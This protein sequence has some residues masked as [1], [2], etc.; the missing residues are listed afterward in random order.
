MRV[1]MKLEKE[2]KGTYRYEEV[3]ETGQVKEHRECAIG[4]LY[5]KK[6]NFYNRAAPR[7]IRVEVTELSESN[8]Q[9]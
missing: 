2:T 1:Y 7:G 3:T 6:T 9:A 4:K 8:K 5:L